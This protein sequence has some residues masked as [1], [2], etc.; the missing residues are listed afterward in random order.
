MTAMASSTTRQRARGRLECPVCLGV[1]LTPYRPAADSPLVIDHCGRCGGVWFDAGEVTALKSLQ[2]ES[3]LAAVPLRDD[4]HRMKCH[5]CHASFDRNLPACPACG[6]QNL[7]ACPVCRATLKAVEHDGLRLDA[8]AA[9]HGVWFDNVE[10]AAIW[11]GKVAALAARTGRAASTLSAEDGVLTA[12][13]LMPDPFLT[14]Y[15]V[16]SGAQVVGHAAGSLAPLAG[17][18]LENTGEL[19]GSVFDA[20]GG[21]ISSIFEALDF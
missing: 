1:A 3:L 12:A 14:G 8:C 5:E 16:A 17:A 7:L 13:L 11:N 20:I 4:A 6:R 19:A 18:A 15:I 21:I 2:P 9:C 10:L